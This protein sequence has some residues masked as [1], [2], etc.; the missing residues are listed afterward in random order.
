MFVTEENVRREV[1][2]AF[3]KGQTVYD[4]ILTETETHFVSS[5][6][7][8]FVETRVTSFCFAYL[9]L[10]NRCASRSS[11]RQTGYFAIESVVFNLCKTQ[12]R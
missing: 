10:I 4:G 12:F 9:P 8:S 5:G 1:R 6:F 11:Q 7:V 3:V 2:E